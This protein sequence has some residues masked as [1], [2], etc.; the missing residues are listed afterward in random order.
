VI[1]LR[2]VIPIVVL[3]ATIAAAC[4]GGSGAE[5]ARVGDSAVTEGDLA[6]LYE[7][8]VSLPVG[9]ELRLSLYRLVAMRVLV[10]AMIDEFGMEL[11]EQAVEAT[12]LK[13]VD[14]MERRGLTPAQAL[15]VPNAGLGMIRFN[16]ELEVLRDQVVARILASPAF[17][18]ALFED[19][20]GVTTVCVHHV[21]VASRDEA[22]EVVD[23]IEGGE[24][25][26][27]I[28]EALSL[29]SVPRGDLGCRLASAYVTQFALATLDAEVG[30]AHG[31]VETPFGWHVLVVSDRSVL[32]RAQV[33]ADP[34]SHIDAIDIAEAWNRWVNERLREAEVD[35]V[36]RY[37]TWTPTGI[38]APDG[39]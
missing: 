9:D 21:L 32:D 26:G 24:D 14:D 29:D 5:M 16:A 35:V 12:Y 27:D 25:V 13:S 37:G 6:A 2:R 28:A 1:P 34:L 33:E 4:A 8:R 23:R 19:R 18:D 11:D 7:A 39:E 3:T 22:Q 15:N 31:P 38:R 30:A 36:A 17:L 10:D 20:V